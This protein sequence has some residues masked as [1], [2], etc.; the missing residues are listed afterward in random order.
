MV[1]FGK[2][3]YLFAYKLFGHYI[4]PYSYMLSSMKED[5]K[6]ARVNAIPSE[7]LSAII[8]SALI[9]FVIAVPITYFTAGLFM[10]AY[11]PF[12][13]IVTF[14]V[15]LMSGFGVF[16][17]GYTYPGSVS[18][19]RR[20]HIDAE[21]PYAV[22]HMATL[23]G[24]GSPPQIIFRVLSQFTEFKEV[25][26]ECT[27]IV[28]DFEVKGYSLINAL[29]EVARRTP[30]RAF[31]DLL[32]GMVTTIRTGGDLRE[33]LVHKS[34]SLMSTRQRSDRQFI[35]TLSLFNEMYIVAFILGPLLIIL[36]IVIMSFVGGSAMAIPPE[37]AMQVMI[38]LFVPISSIGAL[39]L[40]KKL[41]P[42][43]S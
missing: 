1:D 16:V 8:L 28:R 13:W 17:F 37:L 24:T 9:T 27:E 31:K 34:A 30:S 6:R 35:D 26:R 12:L 20:K 23:A 15:G 39:Y 32:W 10:S 19:E 42:M 4:E 18:N 11:D 7:Y 14:G 21:L 2:A 33:Y 25:S 3:Y 5:L 43:R 40:L 38:Y 36:M 22:V 41:R 29:E